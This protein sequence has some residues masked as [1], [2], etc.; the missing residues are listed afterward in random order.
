VTVREP[1]SPDQ[2]PDETDAQ[3]EAD[4]SLLFPFALEP[5]NPT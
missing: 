3:P 5:E 2:T 4:T 1:T